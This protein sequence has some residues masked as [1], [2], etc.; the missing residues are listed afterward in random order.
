VFASAWAVSD[1]I[2]SVCKCKTT[3]QKAS[4]ASSIRGF[5]RHHQLCV[6]GHFTGLSPSPPIP[7]IRA[8]HRSSRRMQRLSP[9]PFFCVCSCIVSVHHH[10]LAPGGPPPPG[11]HV[12]RLSPGWPPPPLSAFINKEAVAHHAYQ[13]NATT[14][15]AAHSR[16]HRH[17]HDVHEQEVAA[18][19]RREPGAWSAGIS[20][21]IQKDKLC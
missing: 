13:W 19:N 6:A 17:P 12:N 1:D 10:Q 11:R 2:L 4:S 21:Q 3:H 18:C 16:P 14:A 20:S 7:S 5:D 15:M 9:S 8:T